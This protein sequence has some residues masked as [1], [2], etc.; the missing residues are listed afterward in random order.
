MT[1]RTLHVAILQHLFDFASSG[2]RA[3]VRALGD[4]LGIGLARTADALSTLHEAGLVD[5][6]RLRLTL[7]G[8][9]VAVATRA[10]TSALPLAA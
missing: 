2:R 1:A 10:V 5:A 6:T 4:R 9:A 8:L 7:S 3:S